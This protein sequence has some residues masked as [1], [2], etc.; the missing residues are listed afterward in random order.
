MEDSIIDFDDNFDIFITKYK[1]NKN[2]IDTNTKVFFMLNM[3]LKKELEMHYQNYI[4]SFDN[5]DNIDN[6]DFINACKNIS[7]KEINLQALNYIKCKYKQ[8][9]KNDKRFKKITQIKNKY[10]VKS[11]DEL[12]INRL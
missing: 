4:E 8:L 9:I 5:F 1:V 10:G 12:F 3:K 11:Q 6:I 7:Q 2:D